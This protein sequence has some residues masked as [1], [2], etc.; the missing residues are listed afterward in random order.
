MSVVIQADRVHV[1]R[2]LRDLRDWA[3]YIHE[4]L[5]ADQPFETGKRDLLEAYM[6]EAFLHEFDSDSCSLADRLD[7]MIRRIE[8]SAAPAERAAIPTR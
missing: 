1:L 4:S 2:R 5:T 3:R 7:V 6:G 8:A